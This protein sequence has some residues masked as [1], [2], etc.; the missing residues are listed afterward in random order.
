MSFLSLDAL[1]AAVEGRWAGPA[2]AGT[3][4]AGIGTDTRGHLAG[5]AFCA[6]AG[7]QHDGHEH[8]AAAVAAG[9]SAL[10]VSRI[11]EGFTPPV[12]TL[13]V[14]NTLTALQ[15]AASAWRQE[16]SPFTIAITGSSGKTTTR[17]LLNGV[18]S[19]DQR[20]TS[21]PKSFNNEIGVPLTMLGSSR[22]DDFLL[23][24]MGMNHPGE[25]AQLSAIAV[26]DAAIITMVGRAHL[27]GM[28]SVEA[29]AAEKASIAEALP[30]CA[31][32]VVNGDCA[33]L[34]TALAAL[35]RC[36]LR[37]S[38]FGVGAGRSVRLVER[39]QH[40]EVQLVTARVHGAPVR[41]EL[42]LPGQHNA[43][44]ALAALAM[45]MDRGLSAAHVAKGLATVEPSEMRMVRERIGSV[46]IYN[47]AYN[48][49]PD[50][51]TAALKAFAEVASRA[52]RRVVVLGDMLE[53]GEAERALHDEVG[54]VAAGVL[55]RGDL[56]WFI[57]P[58]SKA[59]AEA[60][61]ALGCGAEWVESLDGGAA[62]GIAASLA[63]GDAV[64]LKG[65]RGSAVER[66]LPALRE[67][68]AVA[69]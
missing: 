15:R 3:T 49:N 47:D 36:D 64:L 28:G 45:G 8:L 7:G 9:A 24:E 18:L 31:T 48:A 2:R 40:P 55:Q 23:L 20:G 43:L 33:P 14:G 27:A 1:A 39:E 6:L 58:R 62:S 35:G 53:L 21:S 67:A 50:A 60:A 26:Q 13:V 61:R 65:S 46:D 57:G 34:M 52:P 29:I 68:L 10:I 16:V 44:N 4:I 12:P 32:L 42:R 54:R 5:R 69:G 51:V 37:V 19:Q 59:G 11:P 56:A 30:A 63:E 22:G 38:T 66:V 41:F 17:R 25:I